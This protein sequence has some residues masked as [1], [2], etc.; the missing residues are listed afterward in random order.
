MADLMAREV[1]EWLSDTMT[2]ETQRY[3]ASRRLP[4][5]GQWFLQSPEYERWTADGQQTLLLTGLPGTGKSTIT[6][7]VVDTLHDLFRDDAS[8][9]IAVYYCYRQTNIQEHSKLI[10]RSLLGQLATRCN[11]SLPPVLVSFF[12]HRKDKKEDPSLEQL[13][14]ALA[15]YFTLFSKTCIVV[16]ALDELSVASRRLLLSHF[17]TLQNTY[18]VSF[19]F[20]S[21]L[22]SDTNSELEMFP[23]FKIN[24][25]HTKMDISSYIDERFRLWSDL[26]SVRNQ[27]GMKEVIISRS[28][29][30]EVYL[31]L[32]IGEYTDFFKAGAREAADQSTHIFTP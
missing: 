31:L 4:G 13:F 2:E 10:I 24:S 14:E 28:N 27:K 12:E 25:T 23:A 5:T 22:E 15:S 19:L 9:G 21:C 30:S 18:R 1:V 17:I 6:S 3:L 16:D 11:Y 7:L 20:T 8:V 32:L 29:G 26:H